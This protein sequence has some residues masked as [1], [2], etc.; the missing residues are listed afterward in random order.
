MV[1][2]PIEQRWDNAMEISM[3]DRKISRA[4]II[5][6]LAVSCLSTIPSVQG[7]DAA[8]NY[9]QLA[10]DDR[11]RTK[12]DRERDA[13]SKPAQVL[14]Y[15][16]LQPGQ[17]VLDLFAG[18]GYYSEIAGRIVA[19]HGTVYMHNNSAYLGFAGEALV[20]REASGR[21]H[22]VVRYDRELEA[23]DLPAN[24][25]D[26]VLMVMTYHDLYYKADGWDLDPD[27]FFTMMHRVLKP[28]GMLCII[29][30]VATIGSQSSDA[31][32][33]HR[34]DP[35]FARHDIENRGFVF[36]GE[37]SLLRNP[38]D[39]LDVNVFDPSVRR[40]TSRF[41]YKFVEPAR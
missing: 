31:Q 34:I 41:I 6:L 2:A 16:D 13:T 19:E 9:A 27:G 20:E 7:A 5:V 14:T 18:G 1:A 22:N 29:D 23:I 28:G 37:S 24:S 25:V 12:N 8:I 21:L 38:D 10:V 26:R 3:F 15:F 35:T 32:D 40:K 36:A 4:P 17:V 11:Y 30:H 39:Q 33:L